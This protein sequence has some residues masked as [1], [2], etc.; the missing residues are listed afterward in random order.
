MTPVQRY[1]VISDFPPDLPLALMDV[2]IGVIL[3]VASPLR[4]SAATFRVARALLPMW[5]WGVYFLVVGLALLAAVVYVWIWSDHNRHPPGVWLL[6][7][8]SSALFTMWA[9]MFLLSGI[10]DQH[11][12][13][14]GV[15]VYLYLAYRHSFAP[16]GH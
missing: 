13:L 14:I 15:P 6:R 11:A 16:A 10:K 12:A 4:S 8:L 9:L 3:V 7:V 5:A 2:V 1:A